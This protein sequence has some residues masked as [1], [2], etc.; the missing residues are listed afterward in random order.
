MSELPIESIAKLELS[1]GDVLVVK[2][3]V[4]LSA[5]HVDRIKE[6]V[7]WLGETIGIPDLQCLI[8]DGGL[9]ISVM[10]KASID[11]Q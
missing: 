11:A 9:E 6:C 10:Q 1:P 2:A 5:D 4:C 8:L 3:E 7:R